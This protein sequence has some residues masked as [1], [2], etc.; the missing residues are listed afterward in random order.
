MQ[1]LDRSGTAP[2]VAGSLG[3]PV[4]S[5]PGLA[6]PTAPILGAAPAVPSLVSP[7]VQACVPALAG[8]PGGGLS[9]PPVNVPSVDTIGIPSECLLL[10]NMFDPKLETEPEFDLDIK[11]DVQDECSK[12]GALKHIYVDKNSAGFVY[13]R[14]ENT[15]SAISA[16]RA[17][18]GRWFAGKMIT[19][20]FML[21]QNYEATFPDSR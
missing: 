13:L 2:S 18:H 11:E 17:L 10:K 6:L 19:A 21:P 7:L 1:K 16:Q 15:Q 20:T 9:I 8:L 5:S 14:F 12:F 3:T 4:V